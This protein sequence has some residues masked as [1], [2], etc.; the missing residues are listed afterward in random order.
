ME[1]V[2]RLAPC[3]HLGGASSS[4]LY[5]Q[6]PQLLLTQQPLQKPTAK[7]DGHCV[8]EVG[9]GGGGGV[10]GGLRKAHPLFQMIGSFRLFTELFEKKK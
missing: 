3:V 5:T 8:A 6:Q 9:V 2:C 1:L 4:A 10:G 7:T